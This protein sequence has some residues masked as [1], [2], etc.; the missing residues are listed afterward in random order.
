MRIQR[1]HLCEKDVA[2]KHQHST[3]KSGKP[4]AESGWNTGAASHAWLS[5]FG[6]RILPI[7]FR[8]SACVLCLLLLTTSATA[9]VRLENICTVAGLKEIKLTG[10]GLVVGLAG[11]GDGG[12][13]RPAMQAL[14][15]V[16]TKLNTPADIKTLS[17]SK[18]AAIVLIEATIPRTGLRRGQK[19]DCY[20][21]SIMGAKSLR[22]GRLLVT[23]LQTADP[24]DKTAMG[25]ASGA[26]YVDDTNTPTSARVPGGVVLEG[27]VVSKFINEDHSIT[28]L[29]DRTHASF[30]AA[31]NVARIVNSELSYEARDNHLARAIGPGVIQVKLPALYYDSPVEFIALVLEVGIDN[32]HSQAR[33]VIN[34]KTGTIIV[35]GDVEISPVVISHKNLKIEIGGGQ[36][37]AGGGGATG[38]FRALPTSA[39][40]STQ[41][42]KQLVGALNQLQVP[43]SDMISIIRELH[44]SGKLHAEYEER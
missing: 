32:P 22:G 16:L 5:A 34:A 24:R 11:T 1:I 42:L 14:A 6:F 4:K 9:R 37:G 44:R 30:Q 23:P 28:L 18:N 13:S 3:M 27:N 21:S 15:A 25:L 31:S 40:Q 33:V 19:I 17:D 7:G 2:M 10:I 8:L 39:G 35:T 29:L 43:T 38:G 41:Q 12:K 20:V 26:V 36:A